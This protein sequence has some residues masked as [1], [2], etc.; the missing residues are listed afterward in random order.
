MIWNSVKAVAVRLP[1]HSGKLAPNSFVAI[2]AA[3]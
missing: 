2:T 3:M 1:N